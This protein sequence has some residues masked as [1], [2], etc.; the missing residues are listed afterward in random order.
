MIGRIVRSADFERVLA[1]PTRARSS[2][3]AVHH[4]LGVPSRPARSVKT[5]AAAELSTGVDPLVPVSVDDR[6]P[7]SEAHRVWLGAVVPKRH[8]RRSV[9][10][11]LLKR[12]I[13]A[14]VD[15]QRELPGG[16]WVVRL[17]SGFSREQF[18]SAASDALS[19]AARAELDALLA[20]A[21]RRPNRG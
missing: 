20:D 11:S 18:P 19:A 21:A 2:H 3:F 8:A 6:S 14:A 7:D 10:R 16:L 4:L 5:P 15:R 13:R 1:A 12:Q 17:R 9:T